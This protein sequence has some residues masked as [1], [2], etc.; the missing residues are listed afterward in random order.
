MG[1]DHAK[2]F[3]ERMVDELERAIKEL[4]YEACMLHPVVINGL[5]GSGY[6]PPAMSIVVGLVR[7][8]G[9]ISPLVI[10][11]RFV[12]AQHGSGQN[13]S[14]YDDGFDFKGL[15]QATLRPDSFI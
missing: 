14:S 11:D 13:A 3:A 2:G 7:D 15:L 12:M 9:R 8:D 6:T 1:S 4:G 10:S 5:P